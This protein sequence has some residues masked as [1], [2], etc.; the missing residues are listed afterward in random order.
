MTLIC[1]SLKGI[2]TLKHQSGAFSVLNLSFF[3]IMFPTALLTA[4]L[5]PRRTTLSSDTEKKKKKVKRQTQVYMQM[6][7]LTVDMK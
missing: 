5:F 4:Q 7:C 1:F 2:L 6:F 3:S